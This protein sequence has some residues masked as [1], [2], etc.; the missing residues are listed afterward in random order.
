MEMVQCS[1]TR[2]VAVF[3]QRSYCDGLFPDEY[4]KSSDLFPPRILS[5]ISGKLCALSWGCSAMQHAR[6]SHLL[7]AGQG[8]DYLVSSCLFP[9]ELCIVHYASI[10]GSLWPMC[11]PDPSWRSNDLADAGSK[12][13][14]FDLGQTCWRKF[15]SQTSDNMDRW[16]AEV[17]RVKEE[18]KREEER[19]SKR[20]SLR[21]KKIQVAKR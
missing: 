16:K 20:E 11:F 13:E 8:L 9:G 6:L 3:V 15:R 17:V 12:P 10:I 18:K 1:R 5:V 2:R 7:D 21:R 14:C 4:S 19:R